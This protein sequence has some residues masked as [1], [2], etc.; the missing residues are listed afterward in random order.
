MQTEA[1]STLDA[2]LISSRPQ[3][4][5]SRVGVVFSMLLILLIGALGVFLWMQYQAITQLQVALVNQAQANQLSQQKTLAKVSEDLSAQNK[6]VQSDVADLSQ[7]LDNTTSKVLALTNIN[8]DDW[9]LTEVDYLL[10]MANQRILMEHESANSLAL[11]ESANSV[12]AELQNADLFTARKKLTQEIEALKLASKVDREGIYLQLLALTQ[13]IEI[14]P[15]IEP[16]VGEDEETLAALD[17]GEEEQ[18]LTFSQHLA[19]YGKKIWHRLSTYVR[20]RDQ[21]RRVDA[22][23]PPEDQMY[24]KQNL[25]LMLEQ[26]QIGLLR[27]EQHVYQASL[28]KAQNWIRDYYPLND[29]AQIVLND[30]ELLKKNNIQQ[31]LPDFSGSAALIKDYLRQKDRLAFSRHGGHE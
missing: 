13:Q 14:L 7:R 20:V 25:R 2:Q 18:T 30:L 28:D 3:A 31:P 4:K 29:Q 9:K 6:Q 26:A 10:R 22:I 27:E 19:L 8:R 11:A 17:Q 16:L 1:A 15:L 21:G 23:L 12:M 24:L 5:K